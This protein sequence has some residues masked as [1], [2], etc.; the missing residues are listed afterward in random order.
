MQDLHF[1]SIAF[2]RLTPAPSLQVVAVFGGGGAGPSPSPAQLALIFVIPPRPPFIGEYL[3]TS[4]GA[5]LSYNFGIF[6]F[7]HV[8]NFLLFRSL[9][10]TRKIFV[11]SQG[12]AFF[13]VFIRLL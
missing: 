5:E 7:L 11:L 10:L 8:F 12:W 6:I 4:T 9:L 13:F 3:F 2:L 1:S